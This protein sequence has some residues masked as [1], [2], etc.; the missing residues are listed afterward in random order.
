MK[1]ARI[2][3]FLILN[4]QAPVV[5]RTASK[6]AQIIFKSLDVG[7]LI[8]QREIADLALENTSEFLMEGGNNMVL[9]SLMK[10]GQYATIEDNTSQINENVRSKNTENL[11]Y[12]L[13]LHLNSNDE[14]TSFLL[15]ALYHWEEKYHLLKESLSAAQTSEAKPSKGIPKRMES[16]IIM[17][18]KMMKRGLKPN[19]CIAL[20]QIEKIFD[21]IVKTTYEEIKETDSAEEKE[22]K[23]KE[24]M[25]NKRIKH[26]FEDAKSLSSVLLNRSFVCFQDPLPHEKAIELGELIHKAYH[27]Q[28]EP[29]P[30]N[31]YMKKEK[32]ELRLAKSGGKIIETYPLKFVSPKKRSTAQITIVKGQLV[33]SMCEYKIAEEL[34]NY[35][36]GTSSSSIK[37]QQTYVE[38]QGIA[39]LQRPYKSGVSISLAIAEIVQLLRT[40]LHSD[41]QSNN[42]AKYIMRYV[43]K[44]LQLIAEDK[45]GQLS[46]KDRSISMGV[47]ILIGGWTKCIAPG[48]LVEGKIGNKR[49]IC[50]VVSGGLET[51]RNTISAIIHN[52]DTF[53]IHKIPI[54]EVKPYEEYKW[55]Q[56]LLPSQEIL[57]K[58]LLKAYSLCSDIKQ[59]DKQIEIVEEEEKKENIE[60]K[61]NTEEVKDTKDTNIESE[62]ALIPDEKEKEE[63]PVIPAVIPVIPVIP[64]SPEKESPV[65]ESKESPVEESKESIAEESKESESKC[66]V[67]PPT[68]TSYRIDDPKL[69]LIFLLRVSARLPWEEMLEGDSSSSVEMQQLK[70]DLIQVLLE[71]SRESEVNRDNNW[72]ELKLNETWLRLVE[73]SDPGN[74]LLF[75]PT[76]H[77]QEKGKKGKMEIGEEIANQLQLFDYVLPVSSYIKDLP[78]KRSE[79]TG[80]ADEA[81]L[82]LQ[83]YWEKQLIPKIQDF[84]RGSFQEWE[85]LYYFE[86]LRDSL[87]KGDQNKAIEDAL[88]LCDQ[89]L[90]SGCIVPD[91]NYDWS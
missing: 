35:F 80:N 62:E 43:N 53:L 19:F 57:L 1:A 18:K 84:V 29:V 75:V 9:Q 23:E 47:L 6:C 32:H 20:S 10:I 44:S 17:A 87:R 33:V 76:M 61:E 34:E 21:E 83:S 11:L 50:S 12:S 4:V 58:A 7:S 78:E 67:P 25:F 73:K 90:P 65:E 41:P 56:S 63:I 88:I 36:E 79:T 72:W 31:P 59:R 42:W 49:V 60:K 30:I 45:W 28:L 64:V 27:K 48:S 82:K 40:L 69:L 74:H 14:D 66:P 89:R 16:E 26:H 86:Q 81:A 15:T 13:Y 22:R 68:P 54:A 8:V 39:C 52:D 51:G 91:E 46:V 38:G 37:E 55:P 77:D 85:M 70:E 71:L 24:L 3:G 2:I 5:L